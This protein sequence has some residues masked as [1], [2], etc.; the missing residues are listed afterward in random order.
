MSNL[1]MIS[2]PVE[3]L[4]DLIDRTLIAELSV[5]PAAIKSV[6]QSFSPR[7]EILELMEKFRQM[8][9]QCIRI[10]LENDVSTPKKAI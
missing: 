3:V 9:N 5:V 7:P 4:F 8:V 1:T 2:P 10:G 6:I